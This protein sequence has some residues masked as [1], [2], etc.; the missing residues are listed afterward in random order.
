MF[1]VTLPK[2]AATDPAA[3]A[4]KAKEAGADL[5]EIRADLTPD[6]QPFISLLPMIVSPRGTG[7]RLMTSLRPAYVDLQLGEEMSVSPGMKIIRSFHDFEKTPELLNLL[8]L[9]EK[10]RDT[11]ADI[12]KIATK[13]NSYRD[14]HTLDL[15]RDGFPAEQGRCILGMGLKAHL[16]RLLSPLKNT[17][18]YTYLEEG[19]QSASGQVPL[20]LHKLTSHCKTPK[21]FGL[22]GGDGA[23]HSLSPLIQ[24]ML[25]SLNGI[26]A[27]YSLFLTDDLDDA[28]DA[29]AAR[30]VAGFSVTSP[31]KQSVLRKLERLDPDAQRLGSVNT[32]VCEDGHYVG[33]A[34]D[35][36]GMMEGYPFLR[37]AA[38]VA[39]LGSGGVVPSVVQAV[40]MSGVKDI[41]IFARNAAART[42]VAEKFAVRQFDLSELRSFQPAILISTLSEDTSV[43]L[44]MS[45]EKAH[46][47]DLRYGTK[48]KYLQDAFDAGYKIHDGLPMLLHQAVAQFQ[49]FTDMKP[50]QQSI[51][52]VISSLPQYGK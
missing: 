29:L 30:E 7:I 21:I 23:A 11:K 20:S 46:A 4:R 14:L 28:F 16:S 2:T 10:M 42:I 8:P 40:Q 34:R 32:I 6:I 13:I 22:L 48:T 33:Y 1:V 39:I 47:I 24:N 38:S 12:I 27:I 19:E 35:A 41:R 37:G 26:D 5:V 17:L 44:P 43:Q 50:A 51:D 3:F 9:M 25:F 36:Q 31:F 15:L 52:S 45:K 49:L 18:T